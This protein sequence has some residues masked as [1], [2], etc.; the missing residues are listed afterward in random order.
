MGEIAPTAS[1]LV[2]NEGAKLVRDAPV[3]IDTRPE[4]W[5]YACLLNLQGRSDVGREVVNGLDIL[6]VHGAVS[7][8]TVTPDDKII[9]ECDPLTPL[10]LKELHHVRILQR[11]LT[12]ADRIVIR[13]RSDKG[14]SQFE[15]HGWQKVSAPATREAASDLVIIEGA[16]LIGDAPVTI[17]SRPELW[18]YACLLNLQGRS[19]VGG[20]VVNGFD[21]LVVHGA[22][23]VCTATS[24]DRIIFEC[25]PL[26]P[27]PLKQLYYVRLMEH[28]LTGADRIVIRNRSDKGSSRFEIHGWQKVSAPAAGDAMEA[29]LARELALSGAM[30]FRS[31]RPLSGISGARQPAPV[32]EIHGLARALGSALDRRFPDINYLR[33]ARFIR[34]DLSNRFPGSHCLIV[35]PFDPSD[36]A[37]EA[38]SWLTADTIARE[39]LAGSSAGDAIRG[40][41]ATEP[42]ID[43]ILVLDKALATAILL[44]E[45]DLRSLSRVTRN[46]IALTA[47]VSEQLIGGICWSDETG[48][49]ILSAESVRSLLHR[50]GFY[51]VAIATHAGNGKI[52]LEAAEVSRA[53]SGGYT[54]LLER[55]K[56]VE[57]ERRS[58]P[59]ASP[60][61]L[62]THCPIVASVEL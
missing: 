20:E 54:H 17:D 31:L 3:T 46:G 19:D 41:V 60:L 37:D 18:S 56:F 35:L 39:M 47:A 4:L 53:H 10:P 38:A 25:D 40:S 57:S 61:I 33:A 42:H 36:A 22:V 9:F 48:E 7:V 62:G 26:P 58:L 30:G 29:R 1:D 16:R 13:N 11:M 28:M 51:D 27:L 5:S 23:S 55:S 24:D 43:F 50:V 14:S 15:I 8:C 52:D 49:L 2:I 12:G 32:K 34:D 59:M 6:V 45:R 21:L 44:S